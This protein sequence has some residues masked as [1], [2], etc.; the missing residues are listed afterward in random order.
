M[1]RYRKNKVMSGRVI[2]LL[3]VALIAMIPAYASAAQGDPGDTVGQGE[4]PY[5]AGIGEG[6]TATSESGGIE[7]AGAGRIVSAPEAVEFCRKAPRPAHLVALKDTV[8]LHVY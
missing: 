1:Y 6:Y 7:V 3:V 5:F 4:E 8:V 2:K